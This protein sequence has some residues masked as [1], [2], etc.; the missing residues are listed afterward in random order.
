V[1]P[2]KRAD[3]RNPRP[4]VGLR[5]DSHERESNWE[6]VSSLLRT[7]ILTCRPGASDQW[8]GTRVLPERWLIATFMSRRIYHRYDARSQIPATIRDPNAWTLVRNCKRFYSVFR[9]A[10]S[11]SRSGAVC[12]V[13]T[14]LVSLN[15]TGV[16]PRRS[17]A[18]R[19]MCLLQAVRVR[20]FFEAGD[21]TVVGF[22][23]PM[24]RSTGARQSGHD[25]SACRI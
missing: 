20:Q 3:T 17:P 8:T 12:Q 2:V 6:V 24:D 22:V 5:L 9:N 15:G 14:E 25:Q 11:C 10:M 23:I 18:A 4:R 7:N 16:A 21:R 19:H 13:K 1:G